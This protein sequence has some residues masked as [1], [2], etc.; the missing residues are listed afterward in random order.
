MHRPGHPGPAQ[1]VGENRQEMAVELECGH[2]RA[3]GGEGN[4]ERSRTRADL[5]HA[6]ARTDPR[7][8]D[9]PTSCVGI[10]EEV[11]AERAAR[12]QA[13]RA[14]QVSQFPW[15]DRRHAAIVAPIP[16]EISEVSEVGEVGAGIS[17]RDGR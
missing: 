15:V 7:E 1:R 14:E 3:G 12:P 11:L 9:D 13:V 10:G 6:L 5:E 4:R 16:I 8:A 17:S 2:P